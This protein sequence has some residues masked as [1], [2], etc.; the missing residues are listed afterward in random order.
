MNYLQ[1]FF[2]KQLKDFDDSSLLRL[3]RIFVGVAMLMVIYATIFSGF[4]IVDEFEH[5]HASWLIGIGKLPYRDFFEHH[6]PL[7][8]FLSAPIV[9][10]FYDDVIIF[11]VM[12]AISFCVS[13]LTLLYIYKI[14]LFWGDK[15]SGWLAVALYLG[16]IVTLYNFYQF[17]PDTFMNLCFVMGIYY[18]FLALKTKEIKSLVYSFL[19]FTFSFLF[20]QK[21]SF[22]LMAVECLLLW[23]IGTK[24]LSLKAVVLA[25]IPSL[26]IL[27][28][29]FF[30]IYSK[31]IFIEYLELN[32]RF[33]QAM[34]AYF[35]RGSFW[36]THIFITIYGLAFFVAL[37]YY[38][39]EN[40]YFK[41][42]S[43]LYVI[44]FLMRGFYFAP[45][46]NYYT[47]LAMMSAMIISIW[48]KGKTSQH[49][50][51]VFVL[52]FVMFLNLGY[53]FNRLDRSIGNHNSY[54]HYQLAKFVHQNSNKDDLVMNGYD[55]N[56]NIYRGDAS[57]YWFGLDMLVPI[58][59]LEYHLEQKIDVN[60]LVVQYRPKFI[61]TKN[62]LDLQ[63]WRTYG[64]TKFTQ[65]F[66]PEIIEYLYRPTPY[67]YL[68]VLK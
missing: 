53:L 12:R 25:A 62:V 5:L 51:F 22:L 65:Q 19:S 45:H 52:I 38:K 1:T 33:N 44:E 2:K 46:P 9:G 18:W 17:R 28:A 30:Y 50:F 35:E 32:F 47:L 8:W 10:I 36:Y 49:P 59:N 13:L 6:H 61:Y 63:A 29:F 43:I 11:Y 39:K 48:V 4:Q 64:E 15:K 37:L 41:I 16:Q 20:L 26:L 31:G 21:I 56:F 54:A 3:L 68:A 14:A 67:K 57:Y 58:M 66:I 55:M 60:A 34:L 7:L 24:K 23:Q 42:L 40:M 27:F